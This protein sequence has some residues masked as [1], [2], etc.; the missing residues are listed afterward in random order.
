VVVVVVPAFAEGEKRD[1]PVVPA[2]VGGLESTITENVAD[3]VHTE[4]H[5]IHRHGATEEANDQPRHTAD[6]VTGNTQENAGHPVESV[7]P[8]QFRELFPVSHFVPV[9]ISIVSAQNPANVRPE[10]RIL[11]RRVRVAFLVGVPVVLTVFTSPPH[12]AFLNRRTAND[13]NE[14]LEQSGCLVRPVCKVAVEACC[15]T[16]NSHAVRNGEEYHGRPC[17]I[18][19]EDCYA[20]EMDRQERDDIKPLEETFEEIPPSNRGGYCGESGYRKYRLNGRSL[21]S[22][23]RCSQVSL[24]R[25]CRESYWEGIGDAGCQFSPRK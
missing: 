3:R 10:Y 23:V 15:Q 14:K 12:R 8:F 22:T 11:D 5:V 25:S 20:G 24:A 16:P 2:R 6:Q 7:K 19:K 21:V 9:R 17:H 13:S 18:D 4:G 1:P